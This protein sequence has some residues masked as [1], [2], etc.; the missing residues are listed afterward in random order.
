MQ[1]VFHLRRV[2]FGDHPP[3][4]LEAHAAGYH[5]GVGAAFDRA[6]VEIGMRDAFDLRR[7]VLVQRVLPVQRGQ[8]VDCGLH[9]VDAG[10]GNRGMRLSAVHRHLHLQAAV[11]GGDDL[12][13]E[14]CRDHQVGVD[15][16]V[17][18]QPGRAEFAAELLVVGE[19]QFHAA[20]GRLRH[21]LEGAQGEGVAGDIALADRRRAAIDLAVIDLAAIGVAGPALAGRH[22]VAVGV[23]QHGLAGAVLAPHHQVGDGLQTAGTH[24]VF[25]HGI[26]F[27]DEAHRGEQLGG[28]FGMRRVV[29]GR[30]VGGHSDQLL[31]EP[32]LV[33]EVAV[34]PGVERFVGVHAVT[35]WKVAGPVVRPTGA[36][37]AAWRRPPTGCRR[38]CWTRAGC[39]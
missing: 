26:F 12:V 37:A 18:E 11:V 20:A 15:D 24:L 22:H 5:V 10:I 28:A 17:L 39:G 6:H 29:A 9:R 8:D 7:D 34:D 31:Q 32:D 35:S 23:E 19:Q 21:G 25:R 13:A 38:W 2:F 3:V 16:L 14:A 30:C 1:C 27:G 4:E 33:G 36:T